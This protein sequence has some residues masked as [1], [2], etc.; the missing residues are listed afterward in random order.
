ME[1]VYKREILRVDSKRSPIC[2]LDYLYQTQF[3]LFV[4]NFLQVHSKYRNTGASFTKAQTE[5]SQEVMAN[6][7]IQSATASAAT[8]AAQGMF[9]RN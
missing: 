7:S 8:A 6:R 1:Q 4:C 9:R 2:F 5:F 3:H